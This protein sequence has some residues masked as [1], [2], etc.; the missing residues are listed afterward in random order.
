MLRGAHV[1]A[2]VTARA[3]TAPDPCPWKDTGQNPTVVLLLRYQF[4]C[5]CNEQVEACNGIS[6]TLLKERKRFSSTSFLTR[7]KRTAQEAPHCYKSLTLAQ[8]YVQCKIEVFNLYKNYRDGLAKKL[9]M[10]S[11]FL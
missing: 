7:E 4:H 5:A 2:T 8:K 1:S 9:G 11:M 3:V 6:I 10:R